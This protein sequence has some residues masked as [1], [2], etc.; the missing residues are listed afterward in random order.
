MLG[1]NNFLGGMGR[2]GG[3][4]GLGRLGRMG[5]LRGLGRYFIFLIISELYMFAKK[6]L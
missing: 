4:R 6:Y 5:R 1:I 3:M 2:M